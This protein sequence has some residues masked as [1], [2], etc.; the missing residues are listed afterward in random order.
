MDLISLFQDYGVVYY[1]EGFKY[2]RPGWINVDCPFCTAT[3]HPGPHLGFELDSPHAHCWAC[4]LHPLNLAIAKLLNVNEKEVPAILKNYGSLLKISTDEIAAKIKLKPH[5]LPSGTM[6]LQSNHRKYLESRNFDPDELIKMWGLLG[7]GPISKLDKIDYNFRIIIPFIWSKEQVSFDSRDITGKQMAKY[8]ACPKERELI[9]HKEILFGRQDL[10]KET[11]IIVE[12]PFDVFRFGRYAAATSGIA[13]T[14]KQVRVI[15][16][17]FKRVGVCF[18]GQEKQALEQ[19]N[20]LV[21]E[22]KFRGVD[23]FRIDIIGDPGAMDQKEAD[24]I[25]KQVMK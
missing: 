16:K 21:A 19:A 15:A 6:P 14:P 17:T 8:K 7:T 12:G 24:Y 2:C 1:T 9:P 25:V 10:W 13:F 4:G 5:K 18:D 11:G 22:L 20:K 3:N 23:T